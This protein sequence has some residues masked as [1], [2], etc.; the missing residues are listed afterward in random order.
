MIEQVQL[1]RI[2]AHA[3]SAAEGRVAMERE[4]EQLREQIAT[5]RRVQTRAREKAAACAHEVRE[6]GNRVLVLEQG[7][8][9]MPR[10]PEKAP[11]SPRWWW[12]WGR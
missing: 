10:A 12:P 1:D 7:A 3:R 8:S 5:I 9:V 11:E 4:I 2:E 6:L